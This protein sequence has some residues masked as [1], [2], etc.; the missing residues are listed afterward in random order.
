[1]EIAIDKKMEDQTEF[2]RWWS[3]MVQAANR[4]KTVPNRRQLSVEQ[5]EDQT[6]ITK[7]Q[8]SSWRRLLKDPEK[9]RAMLFGAASFEGGGAF[10]RGGEGVDHCL[11][12]P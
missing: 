4:P 1:M 3:E 9:Y 6:E 8:T 11:Q 12:P 10:R 7:Q 5:A 2:V